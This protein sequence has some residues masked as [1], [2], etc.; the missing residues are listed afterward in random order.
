MDLHPAALTIAL[1]VLVA[2]ALVTG[3]VYPTAAQEEPTNTALSRNLGLVILVRYLAGAVLT[4]VL[5]A[6]VLDPPA[7]RVVEGPGAPGAVALP[8]A[9][10]VIVLT[11]VVADAL[12]RVERG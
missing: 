1:V 4:V 3:V 10:A 5:A 7:R 9:A 8:M 11:T 2:G 12:Q 6:F